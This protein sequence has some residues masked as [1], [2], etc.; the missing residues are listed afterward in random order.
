MA[1]NLS[2]EKRRKIMSSIRGKDTKPEIIVRKLLWSK[3][4]RY[5]IHNKEIFGTPDI[6]I[7]KKKLV[8]F[9]DGCFWHGC[10]KC[11]KEPKTN[12]EFWKKK[13]IYNIQRRLKVRKELKK[14][15]WNV[16]EFWEHQINLEPKKI[17]ERISSHL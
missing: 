3:G 6:A 15:G 17:L 13:R 4:V 16:L 1:D 11:Y 2:K 7:G 8:I 9:V 5:R 12:V 14:K 10:K